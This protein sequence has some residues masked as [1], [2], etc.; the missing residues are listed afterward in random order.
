MP[1]AGTAAALAPPT[2]KNS[3]LSPCT[4]LSCL[5][6]SPFTQPAKLLQP[7]APTLASL[8]AYCPSAPAPFASMRLLTSLTLWLALLAA[9]AAAQRSPPLDRC[10][11]PGGCVAAA[12][13]PAPEA[14]A[15]PI[16]LMFANKPV[17]LPGPPSQSAGGPCGS[18]C[19][20][21]A[22]NCS[23]GF[24]CGAVA[25]SPDGWSACLAVP[26]PCGQLGGQ[27]CP[28]ELLNKEQARINNDSFPSPFCWGAG[29][30]VHGGWRQRQSSVLLIRSRGASLTAGSWHSA[31]QQSAWWF[32]V[33]CAQ[34]AQQLL[35]YVQ[36]CCAAPL[37]VPST[38]PSAFRCPPPQ[39]A[40]H[41]ASPAAPV[42]DPRALNA[43]RWRSMGLADSSWEA[44]DEKEGSSGLPWI[45]PFNRV[46]QRLSCGPA[47]LPLL[48]A[49]SL[50]NFL[51]TL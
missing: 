20:P 7:L 49:N 12:A 47:Q 8:R 3:Y 31:L 24:Y 15:L 26:S 10:G 19:P 17:L 1:W 37:W 46:R 6:A 2:L 48:S 44:A 25:E 32:R 27:C 43:A 39:H 4:L 45:S 41:W 13:P 5:S 18:L 14:F 22:A 29:G 34:P 9:Q 51:P 40:A 35:T 11:Q 30:A 16:L 50:A 36:T 28:V 33:G 23:M 21:A 42:S 38:N